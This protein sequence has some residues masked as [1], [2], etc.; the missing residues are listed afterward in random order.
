MLE[1]QSSYSLP[2]ALKPNN[3]YEQF[4]NHMQ[5]VIFTNSICG[6]MVSCNY[7]SN[8]SIHSYPT[9][10]VQAKDFYKRIETG[11]GS[12]LIWIYFPLAIEEH[13]LRA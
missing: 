3:D 4:L 9:D 1:L 8:I 7:V 6:L 13:V 12:S 10:L 2:A 11:C 5:Y